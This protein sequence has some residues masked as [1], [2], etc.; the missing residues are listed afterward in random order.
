MTAGDFV[1]EQLIVLRREFFKS[2][3]NKQFCQERPMLIQAITWPARWMNDLGAKLPAS[4]YLRILGI[5]IDTIKRHGNRAKIQRFSVYFLHVV[6]EHMKHHGDEYYEAAKDVRRIGQ[7]LPQLAA[8]LGLDARKKRL[9]DQ[10]TEV[11]AQM[12]RVLRSPGGR[13]RKL[14]VRQPELPTFPPLKTGK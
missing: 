12:N 9:P 11:L 3:T 14:Q 5:V 2:A 10:T 6:Q 1:L 7:I 13:R 8:S 4:A